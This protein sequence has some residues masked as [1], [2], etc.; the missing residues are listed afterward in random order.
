MN[1]FR[2]ELTGNILPFWI[3]KMQD[4]HNGGFYG[5]IDGNN[6]LNPRANKGAISV[7]YTHLTLPTIYSV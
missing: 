5:Q 4:D 3:N 1:G 7:S 2:K 6:I